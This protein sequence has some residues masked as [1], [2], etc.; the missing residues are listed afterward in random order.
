ML[1]KTGS[2]LIGLLIIFVVITRLVFAVDFGTAYIRFDRMIPS[3]AVSGLV[4]AKP[5][6]SGAGTENKVQII[7]PSDFTINGS[8]SN[9]T[10]G[11]AN[12]PAGTSAWPS[13]SSAATTVAGDIVTFTGGDLTSA[14]TTYCFTFT[15]NSSSTSSTPGNKNGY[16]RTLASDNTVINSTQFGLDLVDND[17]VTVTATVAANSTDFQADL[18][19]LTPGT[20]FSQETEIEYQITY[21]STLST[22]SSITVEAEWS[23]GTI[24]GDLSPSVDIIDYVI[25]SASLGY[26]GAVTVVDTV[27]RK[28]Y[29]TIPV[30][31]GNTTGETVTFKLK[32]NSSYTGSLPVTFTVSGRVLGP[33][34]QTADS[35]V[36]ATYLY[37]PP[38]TPTP[39]IT[40]TP[41]PTLIE[42]VVPSPT[43]NLSLSVTPGV[44]PSATPTS[45][46]TITPTVK[47]LPTSP[48]VFEAIDIEGISSDSASVRVNTSGESSVKIDYGTSINNLDLSVTDADFYNQHTLNLLKLQHNTRYYFRITAQDRNGQTIKSDIFTFLTAVTAE[49]P[50]I[51]TSSLVVTSQKVLLY[52]SVLFQ[53][54]GKD[55]VLFSIPR[56]TPYE[57]NFKLN[58]SELVETASLIVRNKQVLGAQSDRPLQI[59]AVDMTQLSQQIFSGSL[60]SNANIGMYDIYARIADINGNIFEQHIANLKDINPITIRQS[61]N[62][63]PIEHAKG[64]LYVYNHTTHVYDLISTV[65]VPIS[66]PVYS[67]VNG[68]LASVLPHGDYKIDIS[69]IGY[70]SKTVPFVLGAQVGQ[71][72]PLIYLEREPFDLLTKVNYFYGV[73]IDAF[74]ETQSFVLT[75]S[76]SIRFFELISLFITIS[77]LYILLFTLS[78][79]LRVPFHSFFDSLLHHVSIHPVIGRQTENVLG[80]IIDDNTG[81]PI[82]GADVYLLNNKQK[83]LMHTKSDRNGKFTFVIAIRNS[84]IQYKFEIMKEGYEPSIFGERDFTDGVYR[85]NSTNQSHISFRNAKHYAEDIAAVGFELSLVLAFFFEVA[86]GVVLGWQKVLV[87]SICSFT[88]LVLWFRHIE[89]R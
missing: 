52:S 66:N 59:H 31:P 51:V 18:T 44:G 80:I 2:V 36:T 24:Q 55:P 13:I 57:I 40:S 86:I 74:S 54:N 75:I 48:F 29:W 4:C 70:I 11:T 65:S 8:T 33:A 69:A 84:E 78:S 58:R 27:N 53:Q 88:A 46:P 38:A 23:R 34:T 30:F 22:P 87:F 83:I 26:G 5:S 56:N 7:F 14:T 50:E 19:Q 61:G 82:Y 77:L 43:P 35:T 89:N 76:N 81:V 85:L 45:V 25:S 73:L 63:T 28:I 79:K 71:E 21:G 6:A 12:R 62:N 3:S 17:Q 9:W 41:T 20:Q 10:A 16:I 72:F 64:I 60:Q 39:T 37:N 68:I 15:G 49:K 67:D 47:H 1:A 42:T 32:T